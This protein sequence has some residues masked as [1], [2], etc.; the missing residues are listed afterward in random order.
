MKKKL[1]I[2]GG[3]CFSAAFLG[4]ILYDLVSKPDGYLYMDKDTKAVYAALDKD[5]DKYEPGSRLI[6]V[7]KG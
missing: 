5:P 6:F 1:I 4:H 3:L 7:M 2:Y